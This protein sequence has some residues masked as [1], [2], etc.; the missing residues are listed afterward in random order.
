M[1]GAEVDEVVGAGVGEVVGAGVGEVVCAKN[2]SNVGEREGT[3]V[4]IAQKH[5]RAVEW[6]PNAAH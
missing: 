1:V 4:Y 5:S 2:S 6:S 3:L